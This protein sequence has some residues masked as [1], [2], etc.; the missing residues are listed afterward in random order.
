MTIPMPEFLTPQLANHISGIFTLFILSLLYKENPFYRIAEH[1]YVG[2]SAAHGIIT[3]WHNTLRPAF[4]NNMMEQGKWWELLPIALGLLIY[5]NLY[6]PMAWVARMPMAFWIGYNAG[7]NFSVRIVIPMMNEIISSMKPLVVITNGAFQ[8]WASFSNI[9]FVAAVLCSL[10]YFFFTVEQNGVFV[11]ISR[12]G[13][14]CLMIGF[15]AS[16]GNTVAARISLLVGR[17]N[18]ILG[19]WLGLLPK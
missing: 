11:M 2:S 15:G 19:D 4:T 5:F 3:V 9:I 1:L 6:R 14:Y 17:L 18:F 10:I 8:P 12:F 7:I 16:F 13:R